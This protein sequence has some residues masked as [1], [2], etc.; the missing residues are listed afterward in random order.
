MKITQ[1]Q[2]HMK[3]GITQQIQHHQ[4]IFPI[5]PPLLHHLLF[6]VSMA[7]ESPH[8]DDHRH[9]RNLIAFPLSNLSGRKEKTE[10]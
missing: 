5:H 1:R 2:N 3:K 10:K 8:R 4:E 7:S 9:P 6:L